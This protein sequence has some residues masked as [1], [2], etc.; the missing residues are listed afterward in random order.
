M[1][2]GTPTT[3]THATKTTKQRAR[4]AIYAFFSVYYVPV[5]STAGTQYGKKNTHVFVRFQR[6]KKGEPM[7][8]N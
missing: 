6:G 3:N 8:K 1:M 4:H 2:P 5:G 7:K